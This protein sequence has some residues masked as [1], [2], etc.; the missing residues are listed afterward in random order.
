MTMPGAS[1][2]RAGVDAFPSISDY[3]FLSNCRSCALVCRD[4]S[5]EWACFHRFDARPVF[6]RILDREIGGWFRIAPTVEYQVSRRYLPGTNVLETRFETASGVVTLTDCIPLRADGAVRGKSVVDDPAGMLLRVLRGESGEVEMMLEFRPRFEYGLTTP[7]VTGAEDG[8]AVATG[9]PEAILLQSDLGSLQMDADHAGCHARAT[10]RAGETQIVAMTAAES[11]ELAVRRIDSDT[12][13]ARE[14]ETIRF[15]Q[16]W[17]AA[18]AY[19]GP[20][21][22]AVRRSALVLKGLTFE[23][24]GAVIAAATTSLPEEIGSGRNWDYRYS[25]LRDS[26]AILAGLIALDY[27]YEARRFAEWLVRT[28]AGRAAELQIMYGI[29]GERMLPEAELGWLSGYRGSRPARIGNGAWDQF[30]LDTYGE[31]MMAAWLARNALKRAGEA[32]AL[33]RA[34]FV[35]EVVDTALGRAQEPD[36]GIWEIR[37]GRQ[38]FVFSKVMAWVAADRGI[39]MAEQSGYDD[40]DLDRWRSARDALRA[41]IESEGVDPETGAFVQAFGS[42][43]LDASA[44]QAVLQGFVAPDDPRARATIDAIERDLTHNGHVYR[45]RTP[46]GLTG[47]EGTFIFCTLWLAAAEA[48]AG[49]IDSARARLELVLDHTNDLGLLAEEIDADTGELLGNFPQAFSHVGVLGAAMAIQRAESGER[50]PL[51]AV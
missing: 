28:T 22:D 45:Y 9:G 44:L 26:S 20:Y 5:V 35:A 50:R 3:A 40:V 42:R 4:G 37:G 49:R 39:R 34:A 25:W 27:T 13:L 8:L 43:A 12:L 31:V 30:Q 46:D 1:A 36:E 14:A 41:R 23:P 6:A 10:L 7:L 16:D 17:T 32:A 33:G 18:M 21:S 47:G 38:H 11:G 15:W 2:K 24:T 48:Y 19:D 51:L 29:G